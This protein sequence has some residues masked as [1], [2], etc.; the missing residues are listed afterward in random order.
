[1]NASVV[2]RG[3]KS[4]GATQSYSDTL[5][6]NA[7]AR[8]LYV[9]SEGPIGGLVGGA[10][11]IYRD[12]TPLQNDLGED[13][14]PGVLWEEHIGLPDDTAFAGHD[15]V[16]T[17]IA[18]EQPVS[19][20]VGPV[21]RT[22]T[23]TNVDSVKVVVRLNSLLQ[24][25]E[26]S[27]EIK[28]YSVQWAIDVRNAGG[29]WNEVH[30]QV[31]ED[32]KATSPVQFSYRVNLPEGYGPWDIRV[33][34]I[35]PD[36]TEDRKQNNIT[37]ESMI[38]LVEGKYTYPHSAAV[39]MEMNA[40]D[41]AG[42]VGQINFRWKG[43]IIQVPSNY[44]PVTRVYTGIWNGTFKNAW[45]NNP[46]W[47]FYD[48]ITHRRYGLGRFVDASKV[49]KWALY[50]IAQYC[51]ENV[52]TGYKDDFGAPTYEPR[53]T[54]N[55]VISGRREAWLVLQ[56][57]TATFRGMGF[58][59]L[60]QVF[61]TAD[62][63]VD[64]VAI[65][66][67]ANV[68]GGAFNY[69]STATK[70]RYSV[71][72]VKY[73]NP[74]DFNRPAVEPVI[75]D[76]L[77][78]RFGWREKSVELDGCD[79][80]SAA[81]RYGKWILDT[82]ENETE[83]VTY[84]AGIDHVKYA[85][86]D[87]VMVAD[88]RK[89][90][91]RAG[92]RVVNR[93]I[94]TLEIDGDFTLTP[95][96]T[97]TVTWVSMNGTLVTRSVS[98]MTGRVLNL[99]AGVS[100][101]EFAQLNAMFAITGTDVAPRKYRVL[102][103]SEV[104]KGVVA[105]TALQHDPQKYARVESGIQ[106]DPISYTRK[107]NPVSP[108]RNLTAIEQVIME[109]VTLKSRVTVGWT[110]PANTAVQGF[111]ISVS[112]PSGT[113]DMPIVAG[114][115]TDLALDTPGEHA[116]SVRT[117]DFLGRS[118]LATTLMFT[119]G[120][121]TTLE[122][123]TV[124]GLALVDSAG[125]EFVGRDARILWTN[126]FSTTSASQSGASGVVDNLSPLYRNNTVRIY[127]DDDNTLLR[128]QVVLDTNFTYDFDANRAD[129][130]LHTKDPAR[131]LRFEITVTDAFGITSDPT[132][133]TVS[134]PP[135]VAVTPSVTSSSTEVIVA[136][137]A[138]ETDVDGAKVW[139]ETTSTFDPELTTPKFEGAGGYFNWTGEGA[140]DYFVKFGLYDSFSR[141]G[142]TTS[143]PFAISTGLPFLSDTD[144]PGTP[145]GLALTSS[146]KTDG[147]VRLVATWTAGTE[148][149]L[150]NYDIRIAENGGNFV[151]FTATEARY[152]WTVLPGVPFSAQVR[153]I[154][155]VGNASAYTALVAHTTLT[156]TVAPSTPTGLAITSGIDAIWLEWNPVAVSDLAFYEIYENAS[157]ATPLAGTAATYT[158]AA[159]I[160]ARNGLGSGVLR[161]YWVRAVD[162]SGNKSGWSARVNATTS[163]LTTGAASVP[164]GTSISSVLIEPGKARISFDW[165]AASNAVSYDVAINTTY[166]NE[167]VFN[168]GDHY[169]ETE[170]ISGV[171]YFARVRSVN[172]LGQKS[173]YTSQLS[174]V[175]TADNAA[176]STVTGLSVKAGFDGIW[177]N[178]TASTATDLSH[179]EIFESASTTT[180]ST[181]VT[182]S[183]TAAATTFQRGDLAKGTTRYYWVRAVDTSGNK[184]GWSARVGATVIN[185]TSTD[186]NSLINPDSFGAGITPVEIVSTL[187]TTGNFTGRTVVLSTTGVLYRFRTSWTSAVAATDVSG[188]ITRTQIGDNAIS[189][190]KLDT[191]AVTANE[192][193]ANS[194][195]FG[196][197][198]AGAVRA[199]EIFAN[200]IVASH[201]TT[202]ELITLSAQ[203]KDATITDAK[204]T[205]LTAAKLTAGT[206]IANTITVNGQALGTVQGNAANPASVVNS[207]ST[208]IDPGQILV[209]GSTTLSDWRRG[210]DTTKIDGGSISANTVSANKLEI[211]SRNLTLTGITFEHN[212]PSTNRVTWTGGTI[213]YVNDAGVS[214]STTI[215]QNVS[216]TLWSSGILYL[217]WVQ[218]STSISTTTSQTTAFGTN[219]VVLATYEGGVK[220]DADFGRTIID[221]ST[222]KTGTIT[223]SQLT[224]TSAVITGT[225]QISDAVITDAKISGTLS[226]NKI[227]A[228]TTL[229]NTITV[230]GQTL[231]V[232]QANADNPA[233]RINTL[234]TQIDPGKIVISGATTLSDW[235]K[236][237]DLTKIDGGNISANTV[238]ANKME[239][240]SRNL[241][242]VGF[243]FQHNTPFTNALAWDS[244]VITWVN[245]GGTAV[246]T[247]V[248][249]S[250]TT[251]SSGIRYVYW[252]MGATA[253]STTTS[254]STAMGADRIILATYRGGSDL[255]ATYGK[256]LIE[257]SNIKTGTITA[258]QLITTAN[259]ITQKAQLGN[260]TVDTL[261]I[262]GNAVVVP[263]SLSGAQ[264]TGASSS[265][266]RRLVTVPSF[267]LSQP[268]KVLMIWSIEQEFNAGTKQWGIKIF[269]NASAVILSREPLYQASDFATGQV[270]MD[271]AAA[272]YTFEMDWW[273]QDST[274]AAKGTVTLL[275]VKR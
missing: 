99:S 167:V 68:I 182:A 55:G 66:T 65:V 207:G 224:T 275:G 61:A 158:S 134:N 162:T 210:G 166:G 270:Y 122:K 272:T 131:A 20:A 262:E 118:S 209:S 141:T 107:N 8:L 170:G 32:E 14:F 188:Q 41:V 92:G 253:L 215:V 184:S 169:F 78:A 42:S 45:S 101:N 76:K 265:T 256:T 115:S 24:M 159:T 194:V 36:E 69:S 250:L 132:S 197:I 244:G 93:G 5:K 171:T 29:T 163:G 73:Q 89:A 88:P 138:S 12:Q 187:P 149:D 95:G 160:F 147:S 234:F 16:G 75:S 156:D 248:G 113:Y 116:I 148:P 86:G 157:N 229:S 125:T 77:V 228:G 173:A 206:A 67:P 54:Y 72:L 220:L 153:A 106:F 263:F 130:L 71:V 196:K 15:A 84:Q 172:E 47:I 233:A 213:K 257:G 200:T 175:A 255:S 225:A 261:T 11:G 205:T 219:N 274:L 87:V 133:I 223:A 35:T 1:M 129:N 38:A 110:P 186:L 21:V 203:I 140:T 154:D 60:G 63:P 40:E 178:W 19:I 48:L 231:G 37:F 70:A 121:V 144:A 221:G 189:T 217:Y 51:D 226:A 236:G 98:S 192:I 10:K 155:R 165:A 33:R 39:A 108:P 53:Y 109:G 269:R 119:V 238:T 161:Y 58:W 43:R 30:W 31:L 222:V 176:P 242:L 150:L 145:V 103:T 180:P 83:T 25:E 44:D 254:I 232:I 190:G 218:G 128:E 34:R 112:G 97:Y 168:V 64:P 27:G 249:A 94:A 271:L 49:N 142:L 241:S 18:V 17:V 183:F 28:P 2:G 201:L 81:H 179:Y 177:L 258:S 13:N 240:G 185:L 181:A 230:S 195:T 4:G 259:L 90:Q 80:R 174:V 50:T 85:P 252:I 267:V 139:I 6:S 152:E 117:V 96:E 111:R 82:E 243:N 246:T 91:V 193:F 227:T 146:L 191:G 62:M 239:I 79:S 102:T 74:D 199:D 52:L 216:G 204:I 26:N 120:G 273:G 198:A 208:K 136:W 127:R 114:V 245:D 143:G 135:P 211:G 59:S 126:N 46:A 214:V 164:T 9:L 7:K 251:W 260:A 212:N 105:V 57:I 266:W 235:R 202:G 268:A 247:A 104:E 124:T 22:I 3:G 56:G 123:P 137:S 264:L 23:E 100:E 151:G 237:G